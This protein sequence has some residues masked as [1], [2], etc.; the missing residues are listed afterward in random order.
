MESGKHVKIERGQSVPGEKRKGRIGGLFKNR[1][2]SVHE[3]KS[4]IG[5]SVSAKDYEHRGNDEKVDEQNL[6]VNLDL[7]AKDASK[8]AT[9]DRPS[10]SRTSASDVDRSSK[11]S[12]FGS[13]KSKKAEEEV[14]SDRSSVRSRTNSPPPTGRNEL[15]DVAVRF[16]CALLLHFDQPSRTRPCPLSELQH[17][18][19]YHSALLCNE[20]ALDTLIKTKGQDHPSVIKRRITTASL[21]K[22]LG[23]IHDAVSLLEAAVASY[24]RTREAPAEHVASA[25]NDLAL[26]YSALNRHKEAETLLHEA[27]EILT[28][29]FGGVHPDIAV[30]LGN[31]AQTLRASRDYSAALPY[32]DRAIKIMESILGKDHPDSYF[33]RGQYALTLIRAND[34]QKGRK[35]LRDVVT[36]LQSLNYP[37]SHPWLVQFVREMGSKNS[38]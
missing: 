11:R 20:T 16:D 9:T 36:N 26:C 12:F 15:D 19:I 23:R 27:I 24:R 29:F 3:D 2:L 33:Q 5:R 1:R 32:H 6:A 17:T 7:P 8:E 4:K 14:K 18:D 38:S 13:F 21:Y 37:V 31:I 25:I 30:A 28:G 10:S 22:G 34:V 35:I